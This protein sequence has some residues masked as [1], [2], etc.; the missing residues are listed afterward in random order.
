MCSQRS[1][2]INL[3]T[4]SANSRYFKASQ[5]IVLVWLSEFIF[6]KSYHSWNRATVNCGS[7]NEL[8]A[9]HDC[10]EATHFVFDMIATRKRSKIKVKMSENCKIQKR[11]RKYDECKRCKM[12]CACRRGHVASM[13]RGGGFDRAFPYFHAPKCR[14]NM[15]F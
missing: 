1:N 10:L 6:N 12:T 15:L 9:M 14:T 5:S 4:S 7:K 8:A 13:N 11:G 3:R 2:P